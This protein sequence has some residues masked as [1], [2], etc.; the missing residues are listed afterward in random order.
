MYLKSLKQLFCR[1]KFGFTSLMFNLLLY[2]CY[3]VPLTALAL[4]SRDKEKEYCASNDSDTR[5]VSSSVIYC[6][7]DFL[8]L[9]S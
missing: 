7:G 2:L 6:K 1:K 9:P 3:L 8:H 5:K 4:Y